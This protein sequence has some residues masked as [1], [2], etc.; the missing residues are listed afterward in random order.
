M[1][2]QQSQAPQGQQSQ[3]SNYSD[4]ETHCQTCRLVQASWGKIPDRLTRLIL[5]KLLGIPAHEELDLENQSDDRRASVIDSHR[6]ATLLSINSRR[7]LSVDG[8]HSS[9]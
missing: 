2:S 8:R 3:V 9:Q 6:H 4:F 5:E 1:D 7:R